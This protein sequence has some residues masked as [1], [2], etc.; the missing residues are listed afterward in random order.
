MVDPPRPHS[1]HVDRLQEM[2]KLFSH[3]FG[4]PHISLAVVPH[5]D[6]FK[7][8]V[9]TRVLGKVLEDSKKFPCTAE[10]SGRP[11]MCIAR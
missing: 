10:V 11:R 3:H 5:K 2:R 6:V 7:L 1:V 9:D 8:G 4:R